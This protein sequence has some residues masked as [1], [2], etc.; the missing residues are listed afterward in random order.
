M[1]ASPRNI[2][3]LII[4]CS[5]TPR[6]MNIGAAEIRQWHLAKGWKD[7]G[8]HY[9]IRRNGEIETGRPEIQVGAHVEGH[10]ANSIGVCMVGGI[11]KTGAAEANFTAAQWVS[12][13]RL[14]RILKAKYPQATVHGHRE[15][16]KKDCPSFSV[17]EWL[18]EVGM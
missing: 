9:V 18:E 17:Q 1:I 12:L 14:I 2:D 10:N 5:A 6:A 3:L 13:E 16:A 11:N 7:I 4:H 8:Y 15:Y